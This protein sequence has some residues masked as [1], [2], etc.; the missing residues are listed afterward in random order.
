M[1]LRKEN[2][3]VTIPEGSCRKLGPRIVTRRNS[4]ALYGVRTSLGHPPIL[5]DYAGE[6]GV[7]RRLRNAKCSGLHRSYYRSKVLSRLLP[8]RKDASF[9]V[10]EEI[11]F[12]VF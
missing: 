2:H 9:H 7:P 1:C 8:L 3:H 4:S 6:E 5:D 12:G 10:S 11:G